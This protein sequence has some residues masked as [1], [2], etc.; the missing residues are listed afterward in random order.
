MRWPTLLAVIACL[1]LGTSAASAGTRLSINEISVEFPGTPTPINN[2]PGSGWTYRIDADNTLSLI[3]MPTPFWLR[4]LLQRAPDLI[5][6]GTVDQVRAQFLSSL[7]P[8]SEKDELR[9]TL[10]QLNGHSVIDIEFYPS[11]N[12]SEG[13]PVVGR[14]IESGGRLYLMKAQ[15]DSGI[16][17]YADFAAS[18]QMPGSSV[19]IGHEAQFDTLCRF[20]GQLLACALILLTVTIALIVM[21]VRRIGRRRQG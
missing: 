10:K 12:R 15:G 18:L 14:V 4:A 7:T 5:M 17:G 19:P 11:A 2:D 6:D 3:E 16:A 21:G 1:L 20:F 13:Q 8:L 9:A